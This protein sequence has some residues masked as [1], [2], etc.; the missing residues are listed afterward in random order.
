VGGKRGDTE[1][2]EKKIVVSKRICGRGTVEKKT[3]M[4]QNGGV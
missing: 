1:D 2:S 4:T 3:Y